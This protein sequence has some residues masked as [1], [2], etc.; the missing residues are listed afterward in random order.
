MLFKNWDTM[1]APKFDIIYTLPFSLYYSNAYL[2]LQHYYDDVFVVPIVNVIQKND[3][4]NAAGL[5]KLRKLVLRR[6]PIDYLERRTLH[7]LIR[8][9]G[10]NIGDLVDLLH[11]CCDYV[12][13]NPE[14]EILWGVTSIA[15]TKIDSESQ[16]NVVAMLQRDLYRLLNHKMRAQLRK[17]SQT[18]EPDSI[19]PEALRFFIKENLVLEQR[20][21][22]IWFLV[23]PLQ[24]LGIRI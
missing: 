8:C 5:K 2:Q 9:S 15:R 11:R 16:K 21:P 17:L 1:C 4:K 7:D 22:D 23:H 3:E 20:T 10:G 12:I 24:R 19:N 6:I 18:L 14:K 13:E